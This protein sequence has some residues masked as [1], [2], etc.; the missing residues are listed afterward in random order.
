MTAFAIAQDAAMAAGTI[1]HPRCTIWTDS[2]ENSC[3]K[4]AAI[5][6]GVRCDKG[7]WG[8][9][10]FD[11]ACTEHRAFLASLTTMTCEGCGG[12]V[13]TLF[14]LQELSS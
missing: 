4:P 8:E 12:G 7:C 11:Y 10:E 5:R 13:L 14:P 3:A 6:R 2:P 1:E 9:G